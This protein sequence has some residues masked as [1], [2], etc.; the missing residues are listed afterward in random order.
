MQNYLL[1]I[2]YQGSEYCGWQKQSH[3]SNTVQ[4]QLEKSLSKVANNTIEVFCAGRTDSGVH[5]CSQIVNF[6]SDADRSLDAWQNGCNSFLPV[7]I[8]IKHIQKVNKNF[9]SRFEALSRRY[10]YVIYN[11]NSSSPILHKNT[12]WFKKKLDIKKMNDACQY[13]LGEQDFSTFRSSQ[14]QANTPFRNIIKAKFYQH[15][16]LIL[17]DIEGNAFLHHMVR[18]IVGSMLQIGIGEKSPLWIKELILGKDRQ[19]S[20][21]TAHPHGLYLVGV[22]YPE[23][24]FQRNIFTF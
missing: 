16:D 1:Q 23:F 10:N 18:N 6:Y 15:C 12:T 8:K 24:N 5:A 9:H 22:K 4:E 2:E 14:C 20:A 19:K 7:N 13:L 3:A 17:F 11:N 21:A